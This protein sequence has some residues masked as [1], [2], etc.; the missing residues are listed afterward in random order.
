M[1][2]ERSVHVRTATADDWQTAEL[3]DAVA[4][5]EHTSREGEAF[6]RTV[7]D[8][9]DIVLA[10]VDDAPVGVAL[11]MPMQITVPGGGQ[12]DA[13]GVSWVSVAPT[14]RR[15]GVLR[16][17]FTA[18]HER[19]AATGAPLAALVASEATIYGRFGYGP[20]TVKSSITLDRRFATFRDEVP[21][22]GGVEIADPDT[23]RTR[24]PGIYDRWQRVTPG[25]QARPPAFWDLMFGDPDTRRR[26]GTPLFFLLHPDGYV[27]YRYLGKHRRTARIDDFVAVTEDA[28][29]A[30]WR[31]V[32]G[33]DLT[34]TIEAA[35]HRDASL[36]MLLTDYRL[37]RTTASV[38][39]LWLRIMDVPA[40]LEARTYLGDLDT[41]L[42]VDDDFRAAGGRFRLRVENGTAQVTRT[43]AAPAVRLD[44]EVLASLYLG[45]HRPRQFAAAHRLHTDPATLAALD[46]AFDADRPAVMGWTF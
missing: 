7:T 36:R 5:G 21:D 17:M 35:Q 22:P 32:C 28:Y 16:T 19:I 39:D 43:D 42:E 31:A 1:N 6:I 18:L 3:L 10:T 25:A 12:V 41:V 33:L 30:L 34:H 23:A 24:L 13:R 15:R 27:A 29:A 20:A 4:F 46:V 44:L 11:H 8:P 40:A 14:H 26:D 9:G 2:T 45:T 38:D 37:V